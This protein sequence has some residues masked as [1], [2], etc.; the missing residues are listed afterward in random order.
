MAKNEYGFIL[1][2]NNNKNNLS[3]KLFDQEEH[4]NSSYDLTSDD[5]ETRDG[6]DDYDQDAEKLTSSVR[7]LLNKAYNNSIPD[8][9]PKKQFFVFETDDNNEQQRFLNPDIALVLLSGD[10]YCRAYTNICRMTSVDVEEDEDDKNLTLNDVLDILN[11]FQHPLTSCISYDSLKQDEPLCASAHLSMIDTLMWFYSTRVLKQSIIMKRLERLNQSPSL[12]QQ[13]SITHDIESLLIIWMNG[14]CE[15][16]A[17]SFVFK[18][19]PPIINL[20]SDIQD[21]KCLGILL[22]FYDKKFSYE[23]LNMSEYLSPVNI[24]ENIKYLKIF[25]NHKKSGLFSFHI[26]PFISNYASLHPNIIAFLIELFY[27]Y[28]YSVYTTDS[29]QHNNL[30]ENFQ[31]KILKMKNNTQRVDH[32]EKY[33]EIDDEDNML[34]STYSIDGDENENFDYNHYNEEKQVQ[35][36]TTKSFNPPVITPTEIVLQTMTNHDNNLRQSS[37]SSIPVSSEKLPIKSSMKSS[38]KN[39]IIPSSFNHDDDII[40]RTPKK[41]SFATTTWQKQAAIQIPKTNDNNFNNDENERI[42]KEFLSIKMQL[43]M[44]KKSIERDKQRLEISRDEKRQTI[45]HE[46]FKQL[47]QQKRKNDLQSFLPKEEQHQTQKHKKTSFEAPANMNNSYIDQ[48]QSDDKTTT[49]KLKKSSTTMVE[50]RPRTDEVPLSTIVDL[51]KP[52]TPDDFLATL[53]LLKKKY[54]ETTT[55]TA[56]VDEKKGDEL[57]NKLKYVGETTPTIKHRSVSPPTSSD[58][59]DLSSYSELQNYDKSIEKLTSNISELQKVITTLSIKQ[60]QLQSQV[61]TSVDTKESKP[62]VA[63]NTISRKPTFSVTKQKQ[64]S[65]TTASSSINNKGT[66]TRRSSNSSVPREPIPFVL[67]P[68]LVVDH[69][70]QQQEEQQ[71]IPTALVLEIIDSTTESTAIEMEK[72]RELMLNKQLERQKQFE[73]KRLKREEENARRDFEKRM[74]DE[75]ELKK[76]NEREQ[77]REEIYRQYLMKKDNKQNGGMDYD[78]NGDKYNTMIKTRQKGSNRVTEKRP[79]GPIITPGFGGGTDVEDGS[80]TIVHDD[81]NNDDLSFVKLAELR[82][83]HTPPKS[84]SSF[85]TLPPLSSANNSNLRTIPRNSGRSHQ[86]SSTA[87]TAVVAAAAAATP[88]PTSLTSVPSS[89]ELSFVEPKYPLAKPLSGKSNKQTIINSL[90]QVILAGRVN[91]KIREQVCDDIEKCDTAKHFIILFRDQRLQYRGI[92]TYQ[93]EQTNKIERLIGNGPREITNNMIETYYKYNNGSKQFSHV[94]IKSFSVQCDAVSIQNQFWVKKST[95]QLPTST[96]AGIGAGG[97][98]ATTNNDSKVS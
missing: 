52:M 56:M 79:S 78:D 36:S 80:S 20:N 30:V 71:P 17:K 31:K 14:I 90:S 68:P 75:D 37:A 23:L 86:P 25:L 74:K 7:W 29:E 96:S 98:T 57:K 88:I 21:G 65:T 22:G 41:T 40:V 82:S 53:E 13:S 48:K 76:R 28:E 24:Y 95:A 61:S 64:P 3:M 81:L 87:A 59:D 15:Y 27:I 43:E 11:Q 45:G 2:K 84:M 33:D 12:K 70:Q 66:F 18:R 97:A 49:R 6:E 54:I 5:D 69:H 89:N 62:I 94:P 26:K 83:T 55:T 10:L 67:S 92:Y 58:H 32:D 8:Y 9:L 34:R 4:V 60:E 50:T 42:N 47:L 72:K 91:T 35:L 39:S 63:N 93:A 85:Y 16:V 1:N 46:A 73:M 77:R 51:S 19:I 44:K 38:L